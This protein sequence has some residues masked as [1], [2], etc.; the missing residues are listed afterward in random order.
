ML[1]SGGIKEKFYMQNDT[2]GKPDGLGSNS[3]IQ[4]YVCMAFVVLYKYRNLKV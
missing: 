3:A 4:Q 2:Y 1:K